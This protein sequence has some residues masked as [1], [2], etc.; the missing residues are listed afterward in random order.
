MSHEIRSDLTGL[1]PGQHEELLAW[2]RSLG[3]T[4]ADYRA[5]LVITRSAGGYKLHLSRFLPAG[6]GGIRVD[7]VTDDVASE[8]VAVDLAEQTWPLF[9]GRWS[10]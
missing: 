1:Q 2:I 3:L 5:G 7:P 4:P 8:P 6:N 9:L 10:S